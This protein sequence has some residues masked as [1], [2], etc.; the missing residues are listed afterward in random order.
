MKAGVTFLVIATALI[1]TVMAEGIEVQDISYPDEIV[2]GEVFT[3]LI[4]V[5]ST[6]N[7]T[8]EYEFFAGPNYYFT[9]FFPCYP[10]TY[11]LPG[12]SSKVFAFDCDSSAAKPG[13]NTIHFGT[14]SVNSDDDHLDYEDSMTG[15]ETV[16][17][18]PTTN[19]TNSTESTDTSNSTSEREYGDDD[20][21]YSSLCCLILLMGIGGSI[22]ASVFGIRY[23]DRYLNRNRNSRPPGIQPPPAPGWI[24][25]EDQR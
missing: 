22:T 1:P 23:L 19:V 2:I 3:L 25:V 16:F 9:G 7:E 15:G 24:P 21:I 12:N 4:L 8:E 20:W 6:V 18:A 10:E 13:N 17:I 14:Y 5:N 11:I